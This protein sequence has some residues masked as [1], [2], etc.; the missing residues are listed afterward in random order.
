MGDPIPFYR[1]IKKKALVPPKKAMTPCEELE[2][3]Y[4]E[5]TEALPN[6]T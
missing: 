3:E 4:L 1:L 2:M 5:G 6:E